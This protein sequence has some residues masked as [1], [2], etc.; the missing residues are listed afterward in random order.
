MPETGLDSWLIGCVT[1]LPLTFLQ[2]ALGLTIAQNKQ[3][4]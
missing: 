1:Q 3:N 4:A 2:L